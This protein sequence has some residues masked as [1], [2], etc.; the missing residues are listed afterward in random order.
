MK[1]LAATKE[2]R[3]GGFLGD[4]PSKSSEKLR[5]RR[6]ER[7]EN[8]GSNLSILSAVLEEAVLLGHAGRS[9]RP[10]PYSDPA[11][12]CVRGKAV[13]K[14][15]TDTLEE[16]NIQPKARNYG[17]LG[18]SRTSMYLDLLDPSF[19]PK[20]EQEFSEHVKGFFGK[21]RTKAMKKQ[22]DGGMLWR[23]LADK[24]AGGG[25]HK[26]GGR[27]SNSVDWE[28][29]KLNGVRL[30]DMTPDNRVEAMIKLGML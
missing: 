17:G 24:K 28:E 16:N 9:K 26:D 6:G 19:I 2:K 22:L 20:F 15:K 23:R 29:K 5:R 7:R 11:S 27:N 13:R 4:R 18:L 12:D 10:R 14:A 8:S 1:K 3:G 25:S 30:A 21:Q